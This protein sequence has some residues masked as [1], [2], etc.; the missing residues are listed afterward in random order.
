MKSPPVQYSDEEA[1]H[2]VEAFIAG[3][4]WV[5][6]TPAEPSGDNANLMRI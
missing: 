1:R 4:K 2:L 6:H 3:E 5:E